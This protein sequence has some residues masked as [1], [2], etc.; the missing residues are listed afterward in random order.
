MLIKHTAQVDH[1]LAQVGLGSNGVSLADVEGAKPD[2]LFDLTVLRYILAPKMNAVVSM[3]A[4]ASSH[5]GLRSPRS[6]G[7]PR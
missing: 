4:A 1:L 6:T 5:I 3:Y 7:D 2:V